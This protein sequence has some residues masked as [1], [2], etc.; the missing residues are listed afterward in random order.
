MGNP[1]VHFDIGCRDRDRSVAFY[2]QLFAWEASDYGPLSSKIKACAER[3]IQGAITALGH[4]PENYVMIYVEVDDIPTYL[5]KVEAL[6][7]K[8]LI[9]ETPVP[10]SGH[11]AWFADLDGNLVGLWKE[12]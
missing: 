9:P 3:G 4:E 2:T 6:G 10:E 1:V 12:N 5:A 8:V 7:G 11:F